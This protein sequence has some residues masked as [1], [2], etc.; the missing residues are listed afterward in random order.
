MNEQMIEIECCD[1]WQVYRRL[2][3][4]EIH[5][6]CRAHQ[7]LKVGIEGP[8]QMLQ[9]W[10]ILQTISSDR[11]R[12]TERLKRCWKLSYSQKQCSDV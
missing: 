7:P 12:L 2:K 8:S 1:R 3:E 4:L 5:C 11:D 6:E 10:S 9:T